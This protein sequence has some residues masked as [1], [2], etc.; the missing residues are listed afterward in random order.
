MNVDDIVGDS[1][2]ICSELLK[3][4]DELLQDEDR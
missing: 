4:Q 2:V 3:L 1:D